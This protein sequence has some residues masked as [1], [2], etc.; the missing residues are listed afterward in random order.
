MT[1][2]T[3]RAFPTA[4]PEQ[5]LRLFEI[6]P[7]YQGHGATCNAANEWNQENGWNIWNKDTRTLL[8]G[9]DFIDD[10]K[11]LSNDEKD[12]VIALEKMDAEKQR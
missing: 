12:F 6:I 7:K 2:T 5:M 11:R 10:F 3:T 1:N 8:K 9:A 4:S